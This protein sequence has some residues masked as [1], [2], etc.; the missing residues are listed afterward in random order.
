MADLTL[1]YFY[2]DL[3]NAW[4]KT[5]VTEMLRSARR[6]MPDARIVQ[7]SPK[8]TAMHPWA[9]ELVEANLGDPAPDV[10]PIMSK[11]KAYLM[12]EFA[13]TSPNQVIFCDADVIWLAKPPMYQIGAIAWDETADELPY[14][15]FYVQ[16]GDPKYPINL[17]WLTRRIPAILDALP[18]STWARDA[19]EIALNYSIKTS[20]GE[21]VTLAA[22][23]TIKFMVHFPGAPE[24]MIAFAR[25]LDGGEEFK[26]MDPGYVPP[27]KEG[28]S[29]PLDLIH[30]LT[31]Q[32][33]LT[34]PAALSDAMAK[35]LE[36]EE[37]SKKFHSTCQECQTPY[38]AD[39][40]CGNL[41]CQ[42]YKMRD[43]N[44]RV[45]GAEAV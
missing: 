16:S 10:A 39:G 20:H 11:V 37:F 27:R 40:L 22:R 12:A 34:I 17:E 3:N 1:A 24:E 35:H 36:H 14:R 42:S 31:P 26:A 25:S 2:C 43:E 7:L 32:Y 21:P 4:W 6:V 38:G 29:Q 41:V 28:L 44:R 15:Q 18:P 5:A 23:E 13:K 8:G 9:H 19:A 33:R 30:E 45:E